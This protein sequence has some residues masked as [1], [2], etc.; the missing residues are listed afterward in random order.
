MQHIDR[1]PTLRFRSP[2]SQNGGGDSRLKGD[3]KM[4]FK[5]F[6]YGPRNYLG[7]KMAFHEMCLIITKVL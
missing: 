7:K 1:R 5:P 4:A 3:N 6:S 2:S